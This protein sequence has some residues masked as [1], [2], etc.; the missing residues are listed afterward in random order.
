MNWHKFKKRFYKFIVDVDSFLKF[1]NKIKKLH[2]NKV[3][4][5]MF[6]YFAYIYFKITGLYDYKKFYL[7]SDIPDRLYKKLNLPEKDKGID[8]IVIWKD[9]TIG[10]LQMKYRSN[11]NRTIPFGELATFPALTFA[12]ANGINSGIMF[13]NCYDV[14]NELKKDKFVNITRTSFDRCD[15]NFWDRCKYFLKYKK[16]KPIVKK[17]PHN[18]QNHIID[19]AQKY[20]INNKFGRLYAPCGTG[21]T[22]MAYWINQ[23]L[24]SKNTFI[25][26]PSLY[27]LSGAYETWKTEFVANGKKRM[28]LLIGSDIDNDGIDNY[29]E[30]KLTTDSKIIKEYLK[31]DI[32]HIVITTYQ[33]SQLLIDVCNKIDFTFDFGIYDESHRTVGMHDKKFSQLVT[34]NKCKKKLFMTATEKIY[35]NRSNK[36]KQDDVISMDNVALYGDVIYSYSLR[37]AI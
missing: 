14:S 31:N 1:D 16:T 6:E 2:D 7:Y 5:D 27:L 29:N 13:T 4:G 3:K 32:K 30:F 37:S 12:I 20:Y 36:D 19:L 22:L 28:V 21:K 35:K 9:N 11:K 24:K 15:K 10:A 34:F 26:V 23:E 8:A 25:A 17:I 18:Y 33:S